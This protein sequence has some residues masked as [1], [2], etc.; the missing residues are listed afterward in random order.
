MELSGCPD[1]G[2]LQH[3]PQAPK[4]GV[5]SCVACHSVLERTHGRSLTGALCCSLAA[6]LLLVPSNLAPFL[7]TS[8]LGVSR[9]SI[10]A[11]S[12]SA[13]QKDGW[14]LLA[15]FIFAFVVVAPF[16]RF[17]LLTAVLG[18]LQIDRRPQ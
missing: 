15:I 16:L 5:V 9:Q 10:L 12:A 1:C 6:L 11:T 17:G 14:P 8:I 13:M 18:A 3:L 4:A 2:A 7:T